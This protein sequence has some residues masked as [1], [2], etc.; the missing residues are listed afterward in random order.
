MNVE[1]FIITAIV[2]PD[3][4]VWCMAETGEPKVGLWD[5]ERGRVAYSHMLSHNGVKVV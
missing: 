2:R 5:C 1:L 4:T 3:A